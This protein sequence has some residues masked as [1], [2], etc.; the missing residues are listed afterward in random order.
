MARTLSFLV[1]ASLLLWARCSP[2]SA[3][4]SR[5]RENLIIQAGQ[6]ID[7]TGRAPMRDAVILVE[8]EQI[9]AIGR[10]GD[11]DIPP[12]AHILDARGKSVIPGLIDMHVHYQDWMELFFLRHGV[13]TV[14]DVGNNLDMILTRR[15][16]SQ[17]TGAKQPRI[18]ACGPLIDGPNPRWG[19]WISRAVATPD[20]ART[21][22]RELLDR[23]VDC[24]KAYEQLTPPQIQALVQEATPRGVPVTAH[25]RET[26]AVDAVGLGV[27]AF[28]HA[29]GINYLTATRQELQALAQLVTSKGVF[30][31]PTL[32]VNEQ[33]SR[34]L[35]PDIQQEPLLPYM[36]HQFGWWE[37]P[38]GVGQWTE[39]H[40][41]RQRDILARKQAWLVE[42]AKIGGRIVAGSDTPNPY[43]LPGTSLLRELELLVA[44]GLTP[45]QAI[46]TATQTAAELLGQEARLGTLTAGKVADLVILG[47]NPVEDIRQLRQV[48]QVLRDGQ[49]VWPRPHG[50]L[51]P[52]AVAAPGSD[53]PL[54]AS[55]EVIP[56]EPGIGPDM[57]FFSGA[58]SGLWYGILE[59]RLVVEDIDPPTARVIYAVGAG[60]GRPNWTR[61]R[62]EIVE[63]SL[64][65]ILSRPATVTYR[66][67]PDGTLEATYEWAGGRSRARMT[68]MS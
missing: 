7:G 12:G 26:S 42:V 63:G 5:G 20:E 48:E 57:A 1:L 61:V 6:V 25:L 34:L 66:R 23:R 10:S 19:A 32:V 68:R 55:L 59:H 36:P 58:W 9:K 24:L 30:L 50:A 14:R 13:T 33:L 11:I 56:P 43:V 29:S 22:A 3:E 45:L 40:S 44:A 18:F 15:Q 2:V 52:T 39:T 53:V 60:V 65:L 27:K 49:V 31:V 38:Y 16:W 28:E 46:T 41:A 35:S 47:G 17:K 37:A 67:Q 21:V 8:G 4:H 54:P 64:T 51:T 62:G